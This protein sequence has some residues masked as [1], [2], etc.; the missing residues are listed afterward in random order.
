MHLFHDAFEEGSISTAVPLTGLELHVAPGMLAVA[1]AFA[2]CAGHIQAARLADRLEEYLLADEIGQLAYEKDDIA[3]RR[4]RY[5]CG[6][7]CPVWRPTQLAA[8]IALY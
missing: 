4:E 5:S 3:N 6:A 2:P 1:D 7:A 8:H